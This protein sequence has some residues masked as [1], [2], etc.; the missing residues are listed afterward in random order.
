M[1]SIAILSLLIQSPASMKRR[2]AP[3]PV[4]DR[5]HPMRTTRMNVIEFELTRFVDLSVPADRKENRRPI[6]PDRIPHKP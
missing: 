3:H 2:C 4:W 1:L 6:K 5:M